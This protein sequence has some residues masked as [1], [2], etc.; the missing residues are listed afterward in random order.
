MD[1]QIQDIVLVKE[2]SMHVN[3]YTYTYLLLTGGA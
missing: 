2:E 1:T 3:V